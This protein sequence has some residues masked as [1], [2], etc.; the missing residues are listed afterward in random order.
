MCQ[1]NPGHADPERPV[2]VLLQGHGGFCSIGVLPI[3]LGHVLKEGTSSRDAGR[4][5]EPHAHSQIEAQ[6]EVGVK[7]LQMQVDQEVDGSPYHFGMI[8]MN[9]G[10]HG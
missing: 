8:L 2:Q 1:Q 10:I 3:I 4:L 6:R 7:G 9:L 5:P